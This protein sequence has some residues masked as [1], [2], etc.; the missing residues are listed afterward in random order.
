[1]VPEQN[2]VT[3][4]QENVRACQVYA[5]A[6]VILAVQASSTSQTVQHVHAMGMPQ[7][8]KLQGALV[9]SVGMIQMDSIVIGMCF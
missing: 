6:T 3:Q 5:D 4:Q 9:Y 2:S 7:S 8:V 1:M